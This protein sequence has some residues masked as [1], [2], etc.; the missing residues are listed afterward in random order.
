MSNFNQTHE[1]LIY[2]R[3]KADEY[4]MPY[5]EPFDIENYYSNSQ[6][7]IFLKLIGR[8]VLGFVWIGLFY[9]GGLT[10]LN[11]WRMLN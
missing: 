10:C 6:W 9:I 8:S 3:Y 4:Y 1:K 5:Y 2:D 7:V 11:V